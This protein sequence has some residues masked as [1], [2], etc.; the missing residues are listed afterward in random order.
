[1]IKYKVFNNFLDKGSIKEI[2]NLFDKLFLNNNDHNINSPSKN[3]LELIKL[4]RLETIALFKLKNVISDLIISE[5]EYKVKFNKLWLVSTTYKDSN[6][7][8]LPYIAHFDKTRYLKAL[9]YLT[10]VDENC[11]PIHFVDEEFKD[12]EK[13]RLDLPDDYEKKGLNLINSKSKTKPIIANAGTL[14]LFDTNTPHHAGIVAKNYQR[15]ILRFD[16]SNKLWNKKSV[17]NF[18]SIKTNLK[19]T[20][21]LK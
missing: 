13:R 14:I 11:G 17:I 6:S 9:I 21:R 10:D 4:E 3:V 1:M 20:L 2:N 8:S 12:I 16:Y 7:G 19:K 5:T 15:K 18:N